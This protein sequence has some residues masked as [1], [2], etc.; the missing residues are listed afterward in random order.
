M[1]VLVACIIVMALAFWLLPTDN[2]HGADLGVI[3]GNV[4][5]ESRDE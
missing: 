3:L 5:D 4:S 2:E 1:I